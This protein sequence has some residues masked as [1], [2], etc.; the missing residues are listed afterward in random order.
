M[1]ARQSTSQNN[2]LMNKF[3]NEFIFEINIDISEI[4]GYNNCVMDVWKVLVLL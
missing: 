2:L 1:L 4:C 3:T